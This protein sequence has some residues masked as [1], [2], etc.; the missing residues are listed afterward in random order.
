VRDRQWDTKDEEDLRRWVASKLKEDIPQRIWE[1]LKEEGSIQE[2]LNPNYAF[3]RQEFLDLVKKYLRL[4]RETIFEPDLRGLDIG[5]VERVVGGQEEE[6]KTISLSKDDPLYWRGQAFTAYL[7]KL[8]AQDSM[9]KEFRQRVLG[10]ANLSADQAIA[11]LDSPAAAI[12]SCGWFEEQGVPFVGHKAQVL[13]GEWPP[14]KGA[15]RVRGSIRIEWNGGELLSSYEGIAPFRMLDVPLGPK[16][17]WRRKL[18]VLEHSVLGLLFE[19]AQRLHERYPWWLARMM[20]MFVLM[21]QA[22]MIGR[23]G[24]YF[25]YNIPSSYPEVLRRS[26]VYQPIVLELPPWFPVANTTR[27]YKIVKELIPTTPQPSRRRM[28]LFEWVM[29]H[30]EVTVPGEGEVPEVPSYAKLFRAWNEA[31]PAGHEWRYG[32]R[33]NFRRD[34]RKAFDQIVNYYR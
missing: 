15:S 6:T 2:A 13:E 11:L 9:V 16:P 7:L 18:V 24:A 19:F 1:E 30:P 12:F 31:L 20:P 25:Y 28:A 34:F 3:S 8:V 5:E 32:D 27:I 17:L 29:K 23:P 14:S 10:G 22:P 33:R 26:R 4:V 21:Q